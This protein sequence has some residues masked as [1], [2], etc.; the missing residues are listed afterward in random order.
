M[1]DAA[2]QPIG[3]GQT[4]AN[5]LGNA[6]GLIGCGVLVAIQVTQQHDKFVAA[7]AGHGIGLTHTG[8]QALGDLDQQQV[9]DAM[10]VGIVERLE[11]V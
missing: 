4:L 7:K 9:A 10:A 1:L 5:F 2:L 11:V 3:H 8:F 6:A